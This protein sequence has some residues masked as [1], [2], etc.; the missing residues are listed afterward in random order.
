MHILITRPQN[1]AVSLANQ[2]QTLGHRVTVD[3][4]LHI[5]PTPKHLLE[6]PLLSTFDAVVTTSQQAIRCLAALTPHRGFPLWCV[7]TESAKT[8]KKLG[9]QTIHTAEGSATTL[10]EQLLKTCVP[11]LQKPILHVSGDTVR[12]NVAQALQAKG[13]AAQRVVVYKTQEA[14]SFSQEAEQALKTGILDAALFYSPRTA[15]IFRN[16]C[17]TTQLEQR[18]ASLTAFCLSDAI[19]AEICDL[20]WKKVITAKKTSTDDLLIALMM[21][22]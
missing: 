13:I 19:K 7:G 10:I 8:A 16:L 17:Q 15:R 2:L 1:S 14:K 12:V 22:D 18:C 20:P 3:P 6:L 4:L 5:L 11:P 9:F 21:A